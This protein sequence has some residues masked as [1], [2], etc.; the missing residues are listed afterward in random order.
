MPRTATNWAITKFRPAAWL[1]KAGYAPQVFVFRNLESGQVLYSQFPNFSQKQ[2]DKQNQRPNWSNRK[3]STRRDIWRCMC[4][5]DMPTYES[6]VKLYQNLCRL[7]YLRDVREPQE[8][9]QYRKLNEDGHIWYSMQYRPTYAQEAVADLKE[10]I[11]KSGS[12]KDITI[13]WEDSWRMGDK[14]KHW[15]P[16]L[17]GVQHSLMSRVGNVARE[18]STVLRELGDRAKQEFQ[19]AR[20]EDQKASEMSL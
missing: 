11:L 13:H 17:P 14:E 16:V 20:K 9:Q 18:Q 2:V 3:P 6:G 15:T 7:K 4:V 1:Q 5:V 8:A 19:K 10:S 12:N